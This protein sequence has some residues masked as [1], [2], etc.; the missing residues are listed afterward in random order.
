V[1]LAWADSASIQIGGG[2]ADSGDCNGG[3]PTGDRLVRWILRPAISRPRTA[4]SRDHVETNASYKVHRKLFSALTA[5][6]QA[7]AER[8]MA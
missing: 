4:E 1:Q 3:K 7:G 2:P 8:G 5:K 6:R